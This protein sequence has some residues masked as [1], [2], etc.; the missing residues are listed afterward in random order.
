MEHILK[1][2]KIPH[3]LLI[4]V[5]PSGAGKTT[6]VHE[7]LKSYPFA[8]KIVTYKTRKKRASE[9]HMEDYYFCNEEEYF[10]LKNKD[11]FAE[12][13]CVHGDWSGT[14]KHEMANLDTQFKIISI[15]IRGAV[16]LKEKYK[17]VHVF[18]LQTSSM[19]ILEGRLRKRAQDNEKTLQT[20]L[21]N[22]ET[23]IMLA[24]SSGKVDLFLIND[25][26][27]DMFVLVQEYIETKMI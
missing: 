25:D 3:G 7:L 5:G 20:R 21:H 12:T 23:E 18:F 2:K 27:R 17:Y 1:N 26:F 14:P 16:N 24:R 4:I 9:R 19:A 6:L 11:F 22:A 15:D 10:M 13:E 8:S